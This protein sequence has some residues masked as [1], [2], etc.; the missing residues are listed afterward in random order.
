MPSNSCSSRLVTRVSEGWK[1]LRVFLARIQGIHIAELK[2]DLICFS[3]RRVV[4]EACP[5]HRCHRFAGEQVKGG[6]ESGERERRRIRFLNCCRGS[7][8]ELD[9]S[10][11]STSVMT[12]TI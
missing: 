4:M 8:A 2:V 11:I 3:L 7:D 10:C 1:G 9:R 6:E 12:S 5:Y